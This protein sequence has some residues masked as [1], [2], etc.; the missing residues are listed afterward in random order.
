MSNRMRSCTNIR[1]LSKVFSLTA[2]VTY[3]FWCLHDYA[4]MPECRARTHTLRLLYASPVYR[5][6]VIRLLARIHAL[7]AW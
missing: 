4:Q 7:I 5:N 3:R 1:L 2:T 6:T